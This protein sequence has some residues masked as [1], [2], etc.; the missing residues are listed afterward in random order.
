M[1]LFYQQISV[2][3]QSLKTM[4]F[5]CNITLVIQ[6]LYDIPVSGLAL[7]V[8]LSSKYLTLSSANSSITLL[9]T[10]MVSNNIIPATLF[11]HCGK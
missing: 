9:V 4:N 8:L 11:N 6:H 3:R 2:P 5:I 7:G 1:V 10:C